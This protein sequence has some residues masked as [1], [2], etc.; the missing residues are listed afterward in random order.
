MTSAANPFL[1]ESLG[2]VLVWGHRGGGFELPSNTLAAVEAFPDVALEIDAQPTKDLASGNILDGIVV[3][4]DDVLD[5]STDGSGAVSD[6]SFAELQ[7]FDPAYFWA[8]GA[9][10]DRTAAE[11]PMRGK[12]KTD[13]KFRIPRLFDV[14]T[15]A[16]GRR[17]SI[18][19]KK[20]GLAEGV[21]RLLDL[22][23]MATST[24]VQSFSEERVDEFQK[25]RPD[26]ATGMGAALGVRVVM[27]PLAG[28]V[29]DVHGHQVLSA[30]HKVGPQKLTRS[31][32]R[33]AHDRGLAVHVWTV[34]DPAEVMYYLQIGVDGIMT[35]RPSVIAPIVAEFNKALL[36]GTPSRGGRSPGFGHP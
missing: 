34:N 18:D 28:R 29:K 24:V 11:F 17:V 25:L 36:L 26:V 4:H 27:A 23:G 10:H 5:N 20:P 15:S 16:K 22:T 7:Q 1:R 12:Y 3:F 21:S 6:F 35:D 32:V 14:L 19:L 8:S 13:P 31:M 30:A 9:I 33:K 2:G